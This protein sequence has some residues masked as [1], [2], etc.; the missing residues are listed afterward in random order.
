MNTETREQI[1]N[2][3]VAFLGDRPTRAF[4]VSEMTRKRDIRQAVD[5]EF[6]ES[7]V[8]DALA[9]LMGFGLVRAVPRKLAGLDDYQATAE[10]VVFRERNLP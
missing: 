4:S 8:K 5:A 3:L 10:G 6:D 7:H 1:R 9:V 2:A